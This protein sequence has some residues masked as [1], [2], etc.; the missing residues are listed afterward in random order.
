M[1]SQWALWHL[2][3][4]H[5]TPLARPQGTY[6]ASFFAIP[7]ARAIWAFRENK[8]ITERNARRRARAVEGMAAAV[9]AADSGKAQQAERLKQAISLV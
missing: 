2:T 9:T 7:C 3:W 8:K 4:G 1:P 5:R 6:A